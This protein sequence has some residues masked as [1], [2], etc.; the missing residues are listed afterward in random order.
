MKR[1]LFIV[2]SLFLL[3]LTNLN[4][5]AQIQEVRIGVDGMY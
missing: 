2:V 5:F 1:I 3:G 4:L